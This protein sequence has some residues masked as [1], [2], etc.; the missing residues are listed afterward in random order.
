LDGR[1]ENLCRVDFEG[2]YPRSL[3]VTPNGSVYV[4]MRHYVARIEAPG[5][6]DCTVEWFVPEGCARFVER[7]VDCVCAS[8]R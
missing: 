3:A 6:R 8:D 5:E 7:D 4:G 1:I 2:L